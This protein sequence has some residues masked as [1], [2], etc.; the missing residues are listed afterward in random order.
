MPSRLGWVPTDFARLVPS[1]ATL[2]R[3]LDGP[4]DATLHA[5]DRTIETYVT[6]EVVCDEAPLTGSGWA[7]VTNEQVQKAKAASRYLANKKCTA[8]LATSQNQWELI[9]DD[10]R[11]ETDYEPEHL[12]VPISTGCQQ[13]RTVESG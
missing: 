11:F 4:L 8:F 6:Q 10:V 5:S 9:I 3:L 1:A 12:P 13:S 2:P 7:E